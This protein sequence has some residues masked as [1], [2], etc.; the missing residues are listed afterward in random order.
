LDNPKSLGLATVI[1]VRSRLIRTFV[2]AR[3]PVLP[4]TLIRSFR[5]FSKDAISRTLSSTGAA[6]S[7]TNLTVDFFDVFFA[8]FGAYIG[9][10]R[11]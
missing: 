2:C 4:S 7:M 10:E 6:Q 8:T 11:T 3:F 5:Y 1:F 9:E